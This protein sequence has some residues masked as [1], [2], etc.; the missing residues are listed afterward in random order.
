MS[1]C[2]IS[3][4]VFLSLLY[5][6]G[7]EDFDVVDPNAAFFSFSTDMRRRCFNVTITDDSLFEAQE[8]FTVVAIGIPS[9][10]PSYTIRDDTVTITM[11]DNDRKLN[12]K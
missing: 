8:N 10:I 2:I 12:D 4:P 6:I 1:L 5:F 11:L 3:S 7:G 9:T